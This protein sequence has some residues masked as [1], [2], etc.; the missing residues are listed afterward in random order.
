MFKKPKY[1][2]KN[3]K[4]SRGKIHKISITIFDITIYSHKI[5]INNGYNENFLQKN[6]SKIITNFLDSQTLKIA[7]I[8]P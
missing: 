4:M 1:Y 3:T 8:H 6:I 7:V 2:I 5:V